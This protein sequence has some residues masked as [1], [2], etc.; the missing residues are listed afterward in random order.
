MAFDRRAVSNAV[1]TDSTCR[2]SPTVSRTWSI[3][4]CASVTALC[5]PPMAHSLRLSGGPGFCASPILQCFLAKQ[6][7]RQFPP[8]TSAWQFS[9]Q[10]CFSLSKSFVDRLEESVLLTLVHSSTARQGHS[11]GPPVAPPSSGL[12]ASCFCTGP[13]LGP[14]HPP[15]SPLVELLA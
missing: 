14:V 11:G 13:F 2:L 5:A 6:C 8:C 9:S 12:S 7:L 10:N 1:I 4:F 3:C 15:S